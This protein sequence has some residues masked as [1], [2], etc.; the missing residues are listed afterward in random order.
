MPHSRYT[1]GPRIWKVD[2]PTRPCSIP[3]PE[4][5]SD[6]DLAQRARATSTLVLRC[7]PPPR[8]MQTPQTLPSP[9]TVQTLAVRRSR[10]CNASVEGR[11]VRLL[12]RS[13]PTPPPPRRARP[14]S[15]CPSSAHTLAK[16][17]NDPRSPKW[18][19][20]ICALLSLQWNGR[21][22]RNREPSV[23]HSW[24]FRSVMQHPSILPRRRSHPAQRPPFPTA[25][26]PT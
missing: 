3:L 19:A 20:R 18:V 15:E 1:R 11:H 2:V 13:R 26:N 8:T 4:L 24:P 21:R 6:S 12:F 25:T 17:P 23:L 5:V 14:T 22:Q 10:H 16:M 9:Q 7:T